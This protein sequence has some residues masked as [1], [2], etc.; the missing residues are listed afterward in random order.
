[1]GGHA[2]L[3]GHEGDTNERDGH[4]G[5]FAPSPALEPEQHRENENVDRSHADDYGGVLNGGIV[6]AGREAHLIY[7]DTEE[8]QVEERPVIASGETQFAPGL[9]VGEDR[10]TAA[11]EI[12]REHD[13]ARKND[14]ER[15]HR[16]GRQAAQTDFCGDEVHRPN[17][18]DQGQRESDE[19]FSRR[20]ASGILTVM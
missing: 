16:Q 19:A 8:A 7:T 4:P 10:Q 1:M 3:T 6:E 13:D 18:Y 9:P 17:G 12:G 14:A 5:D 11:A 20:N 2:G 15:C